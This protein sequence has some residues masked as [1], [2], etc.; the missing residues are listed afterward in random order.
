MAIASWIPPAR[1]N[2]PPKN[3]IAGNWATSLYCKQNI[4]DT[5]QDRHAYISA[6]PKTAPTK[7]RTFFID[8]GFNSQLEF[9]LIPLVLSQTKD[10]PPP[11][12]CCAHSTCCNGWGQGCWSGWLGVVQYNTPHTLLNIMIPFPYTTPRN[13]VSPKFVI[14]IW[15]SIFVI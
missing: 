6:V 4:R 8:S 3:T 12:C 5:R 13:Y 10:P 14:L 7:L 15:V 2:I 9:H 11:L 1:D